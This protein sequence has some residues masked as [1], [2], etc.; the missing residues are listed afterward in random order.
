AAVGVPVRLGVVL[1]LRAVRVPAGTVLAGQL[2]RPPD[3]VLAQVDHV[4]GRGP[5]GDLAAGRPH[6][7]A[8]AHEL[9]LLVRPVADA[10]LGEPL[11]A[12]DVGHVARHAAGDDTA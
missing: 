10:V 1:A 3:D 9:E 5:D 6:L 12:R 7:H 11:L 4:Q 2:D 8:G